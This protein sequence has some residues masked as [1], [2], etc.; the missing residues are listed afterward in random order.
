MTASLSIGIAAA[1]GPDAAVVLAPV[2]EQRGFH[3]LWV[4][5]TPGADALAVLAAAAS[6]TDRLVL[7]TGVLPVDRRSSDEILAQIDGLA[8]PT[9]RLVLGIGAGQTAHGALDRVRTAATGLRERTPARI[10]V[11]A[12]GP[13]M[14]Q[15][16]AE[17]SDGVL[18][19]W[20]PQDIAADQAAQAH[21]LTPGTHVALYVRTA[22]DTASIPRLHEESARYGSYPAYAANFTRLGIGPLDTVIDPDHDRLDAYRAGVDEVVLRAITPGDSPA[23]Y[24][25]FVEAVPL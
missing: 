10:V 5:D 17:D 11:G 12:L 7:A 6:V 22:M 3:A 9:D 2:L 15:L 21:D 14:R 13:K 24:V 18:L 8:L 16:G 25:R 19:S 4:N 1:A 20:L 23:D